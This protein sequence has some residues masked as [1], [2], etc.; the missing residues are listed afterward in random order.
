ML[1]MRAA[2]SRF[3]SL[4]AWRPWCYL[5]CFGGC[6]S[7]ARRPDRVS[8]TAA[9]ITFLLAALVLPLAVAQAR[10]LAQSASRAAVV[11]RFDDQRTERRCVA[12]D[13]LEI[14]GYALLQRSGLALDVQAQGQGGLVCA[15]EGTG[16][17]ADNCLCQCQGDPCVYWSYW[18]LGDDGW[19][20][21]TVG[22]SARQLANG[23][24]DGWSWG[25][26]SLT[27][28]VEPPAATFEEVCAPDAPLSA[29][30]AKA[31]PE[32]AT[33]WLLYAVFAVLLVAIGL[34][35]WLVPRWRRAP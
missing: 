10:G 8:R 12:F 28:A 25:P 3:G 1:M 23:D 17:G 15:I 21:S 11:V 6:V 34:G 4:P 19:D 30:Q 35:A 26:G 22:A 9:F 31:E 20:Y 18:R 16:C 7:A 5:P 14:S 32:P 2:V 13:G 27:S 29:G 24:V 33:D